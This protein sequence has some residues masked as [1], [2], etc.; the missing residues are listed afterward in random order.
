MDA[1]PQRKTDIGPP[2][3]R[4]FLPPIIEKNYG[5]WKYHEVLKPGVMVHVAESGD[6]LYTVRGGSPRLLGT[7]RIRQFAAL[8]DKYSG[9]HLRFTSRHNVEF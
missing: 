1:A 6:R 7:K 8:A 5:T 3:Y 4:K 9:G 2:D